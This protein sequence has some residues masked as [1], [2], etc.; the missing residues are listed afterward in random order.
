MNLPGY[1]C[2]HIHTCVCVCVCVY[3]LLIHRV[4]IH[5]VHDNYQCGNVCQ[6]VNVHYIFLRQLF[7]AAPKRF[8]TK[9]HC[10]VCV[11]L[12]VIYNANY[13]FMVEEKK[14]TDM[15][16]RPSTPTACGHRESGRVAR[17]STAQYHCRLHA[18]SGNR[19]FLLLSV[20]STTFGA[21]TPRWSC[22]RLLYF[23][24]CYPR[25]RSTGAPPLSSVLCCLP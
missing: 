15:K 6:C 25:A 13:S 10:F 16:A 5:Q 19:G 11:R 22:C 2:V 12:P 24:T 8:R 3:P 23:A 7:F 4:P 21:R 18:A 1:M 14:H 9:C 17:P 20:I